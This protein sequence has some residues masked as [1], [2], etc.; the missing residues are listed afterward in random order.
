[1]GSVSSTDEAKVVVV[2]FDSIDRHDLRAEAVPYGLEL[3]RRT[4]SSLALLLLLPHDTAIQAPDDSEVAEASRQ[5]GEAMA[6][7]LVQGT[8][9]ADLP[10]ATALRL[11]DPS[12]ELMKFLAG[13][14]TVTAIVWGGQGNPAPGRDHWLARIR[15]RLGVPVVVPSL[16]RGT[17]THWHNAPSR[18]PDKERR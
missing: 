7:E 13:L 14:H 15:D 6:A 17:E 3:A 11:G 18:V 16:R 9:G 10:V 1:M 4:G 2:L 12:S 8:H 5:D